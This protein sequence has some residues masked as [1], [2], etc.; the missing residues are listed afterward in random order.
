LSN[1]FISYA[2]PDRKYADELCAQLKRLEIPY[3]IAFECI[4]PGDLYSIAIDSA[5]Q[6]CSVFL[7]LLSEHSDESGDVNRE[8]ALAA[9]FRKRITP[10]RL[11]RIE[12]DKLRYWLQGLHWVDW[13]LADQQLEVIAGQTGQ[14]ADNP[15]PK[16]NPKDGLTYVWIPPSATIRGF[17]LSQTPVTQAAYRRVTGQ[18]PSHF[19]G[20]QLPVESATWFEADAYCKA[21]GGRLPTEAEWKHAAMGGT[22]RGSY[23][24]LDG[25]AWYTENSN[26][27]THPVA[28]KQRNP[29][30]LCDMLGNIW[31]WTADWYEADRYRVLR[32]GAWNLSLSYVRISVR[33]RSNPEK[34]NS[35]CGFRPVVD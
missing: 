2:S 24:N 9:R 28:M 34:R 27:R 22:S 32:G 3:W 29:Y 1:I 17:W 35:N 16:V 26:G 8:L 23:D 14:P 4:N 30:G 13:P 15:A 10:V 6:S 12:S 25:S 33:L 5:I 11:Q 19:K 7:L 31:E 18:N 21:V 20:D